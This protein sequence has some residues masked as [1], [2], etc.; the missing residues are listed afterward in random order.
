[1]T[2]TADQT[3]TLVTPLRASNLQ[4]A[5]LHPTLT[6]FPTLSSPHPRRGLSTCRQVWGT[7]SAG[8]SPS[9]PRSGGN[10]PMSAGPTRGNALSQKSAVQNLEEPQMGES[11]RPASSRPQERRRRIGRFNGKTKLR[12]ISRETRRRRPRRRG[13]FPGARR[14][15]A[16]AKAWVWR[17]RDGNAGREAAG[18]KGK[19]GRRR[20]GG[21][22]VPVRQHKQRRRPAHGGRRRVREK[23]TDE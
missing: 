12:N 13:L 14:R 15:E 4:A 18:E 1:M 9:L 23:E 20:R 16:V 10:M 7:V 11:G 5:H 22:P 6:P 2:L 8:R 3:V 19:G 17:R 21:V